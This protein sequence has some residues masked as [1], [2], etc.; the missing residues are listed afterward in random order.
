MVI[1]QVTTIVPIVRVFNY[2]NI[3]EGELSHGGPV[4]LTHV[5]QGPL[6]PDGAQ[7]PNAV[8]GDTHKVTYFFEPCLQ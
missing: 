5:F 6:G 4:T 3:L 1:L 7:E 8:I 2:S